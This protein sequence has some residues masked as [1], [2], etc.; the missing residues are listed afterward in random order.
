MIIV[1]IRDM[2]ECV[3]MPIL[4]LRRVLLGFLAIFQKPPGGHAWPAWRH[5]LQTLVSRFSSWTA[6]RL[7]L[8]K[9]VG[10]REPTRLTTGSSWVGL[11]S[12]YK[13][14]YR[15]IFDPAHLE[16]DSFGLNPWWAGL[17]HQPA[18]KNV[19]QVFFVK[20]GFTFG[21]C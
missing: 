19:T 18:E 3:G 10:T 8:S 20:L 11:K 7:E 6:W 4:Y 14:Q 16:P 9:W 15:M 13:F 1:C 17:A 5:K 12:F 21:S 2:L